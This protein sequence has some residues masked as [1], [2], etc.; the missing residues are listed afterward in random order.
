MP[1]NLAG[2]STRAVY[3][4]SVASELSGV[5]QQSLRLYESKGLLAPARTG[6][7][8]RRYSDDDLIRVRRISELLAGGV[9]LAGVARIL[10][11]E[12]DN[13]RL[14]ADN[15]RLEGLKDRLREG[16]GVPTI[17]VSDAESDGA[18]CCG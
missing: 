2:R 7:G 6:G 5:E 18:R 13:T 3:G 14:E 16:R 1:A 4:I 15:A 11:L 12:D 17:E 9:N 10:A 8:T